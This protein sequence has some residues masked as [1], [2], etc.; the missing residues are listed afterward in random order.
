ME[1]D[2]DKAKKRRRRGGN[3]AQRDIQSSEERPDEK[4]EEKHAG[5]DYTDVGTMTFGNQNTEKLNNCV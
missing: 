4:M 5:D 1:D 3:C 2:D